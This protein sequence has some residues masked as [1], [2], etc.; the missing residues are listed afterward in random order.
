[1]RIL[2]TLVTKDRDGGIVICDTIRYKDKLWLVPYWN[3]NMTEGWKTPGRLIR[4]DTLPYQVAPGGD[5]PFKFVL[6]DPLPKSL[7]EHHIRPPK[8][9]VYEVADA[10]E[11]HISIFSRGKWG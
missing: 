2:G 7:L 11:I 10:P 3:E 5:F 8:K 4:L 6:E 9:T 1:M